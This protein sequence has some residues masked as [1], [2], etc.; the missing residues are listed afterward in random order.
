MASLETGSNVAFLRSETAKEFGIRS[1]LFL[2]SATGVWEVGSIQ[3]A[4]SLEAFLKDGKAA[5]AISEKQG[6]AEILKSLQAL[7]I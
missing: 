5:Q 1:V 4:D 3:V 7:T 2:P 6:A